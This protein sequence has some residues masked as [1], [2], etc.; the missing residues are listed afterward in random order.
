MFRFRKENAARVLF[1]PRGRVFLRDGGGL[2]SLAGVLALTADAK[3]VLPGISLRQYH[4]S[5]FR[6]IAEAVWFR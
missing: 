3:M 4:F 1:G 5:Y 6:S 2:F